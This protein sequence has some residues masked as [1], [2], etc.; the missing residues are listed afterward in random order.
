MPCLSV[1]RTNTL[2]GTDWIFNT[3]LGKS[4][5]VGID[6]MPLCGLVRHLE[7][8]VVYYWKIHGERKLVL[9]DWKIPFY[10]HLVSRAICVCTKKT[11]ISAVSN[12]GLKFLHVTWRRSRSGPRNT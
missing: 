12:W 10:L 7:F 5:P 11:S 3:P 4:Q 1:L 8:P 2:N 9:H 6:S